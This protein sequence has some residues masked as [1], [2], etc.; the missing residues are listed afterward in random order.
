MPQRASAVACQH[1]KLVSVWLMA[2]EIEISSTIGHVVLRGL[3]SF[4]ISST[5]QYP[6]FQRH[7]SFHIHI[8][9]H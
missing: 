3:A 9:G 8:T 5:L 6:T 2:A 7:S 4:L 1:I